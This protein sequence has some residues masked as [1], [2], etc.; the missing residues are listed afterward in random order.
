[1]MTG[2]ERT[3]KPHVRRAFRYSSDRF[4][5][6]AEYSLSVLIDTTLKV[7]KQQLTIGVVVGEVAQCLHGVTPL[8]SSDR[9]PLDS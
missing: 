3:L 9:R 7:T 5:S 2:S 4:L 6:K 8:R 1:M